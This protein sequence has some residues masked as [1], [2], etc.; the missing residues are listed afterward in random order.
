[1][2]LESKLPWLVVDTLRRF[3]SVPVEDW[4]SSLVKL[5]SIVQIKLDMDTVI[6]NRLSW[7]IA[8]FCRISLTSSGSTK[9]EVEKVLG[10]VCL[11]QV[12]SDQCQKVA[13]PS[14]FVFGE[15]GI[16]VPASKMTKFTDMGIK[17]GFL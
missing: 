9:Q 11:I 7:M 16:K 5:D 6:K 14:I 1:M 17:K 4:R 12:F 15:I 10:S 3:T 13:A 8:T 2:L